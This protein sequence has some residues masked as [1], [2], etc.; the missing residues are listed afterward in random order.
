MVTAPVSGSTSTSQTWLPL[1]WLGGVGSK[2]PVDVEADTEL[3]GQR[4]HRSIGGFRHVDQR[5][6][7]VGAGDPIAAVL[8]LD[9]AGV[10]LHHG[11]GALLA[12]LDHLIGGG[13]QR[14][15]ADHGRARAVGAAPDRHLGGIALHVADAL[16]RHA[17]NSCAI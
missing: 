8:E 10:G 15:A 17:Q 9:V 2:L 1:G 5:D 13:F 14:V 7:L 3:A 6:R 4:T 11:G 12:L 16:E